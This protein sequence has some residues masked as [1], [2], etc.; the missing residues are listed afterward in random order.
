M[1][2]ASTTDVTPIAPATAEA[3]VWTLIRDAALAGLRLQAAWELEGIGLDR[4][5]GRTAQVEERE[6]RLV[7]IHRATERA[8]TW[9]PAAGE[10]PRRTP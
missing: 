3:G 10:I 1:K 2:T 5:A 8:R 7:D 6:Q 4:Q 9:D